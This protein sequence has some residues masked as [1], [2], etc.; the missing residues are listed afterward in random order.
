M[1]ICCY[2]SN[3]LAPK[4]HQGSPQSLP[5]FSNHWVGLKWVSGGRSW[6][7][8]S[9]PSTGWIG[10]LKVVQA[11]PGKADGQLTEGS[12]IK[13]SLPLNIELRLVE[14]TRKII[15]IHL[16]DRAMRAH[17]SK[18]QPIHFLFP[19]SALWTESYVKEKQLVIPHTTS[20]SRA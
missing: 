19:L 16:R 5:C 1:V 4:M 9:W 8:K 2:S 6:G 11:S 14:K 3:W 18:S 17:I 10:A 20:V 13:W 15:I 12:L 7:I